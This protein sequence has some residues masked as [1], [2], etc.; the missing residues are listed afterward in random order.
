M[1]QLLLHNSQSRALLTG[2]TI[3]I[4]ARIEMVCCKMQRDC[5]GASSAP[6]QRY[7]RSWSTSRHGGDIV[8]SRLQPRHIS[9]I[10]GD[11]RSIRQLG[12]M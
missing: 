4:N 5:P 2:S 11:W 1:K 7:V 12:D 10:G 9:L 3:Q 6:L 8:N